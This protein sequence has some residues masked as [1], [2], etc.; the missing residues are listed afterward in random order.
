MSDRCELDDAQDAEDRDGILEMSDLTLAA[1]TDLWAL[2]GAVRPVL[3]GTASSDCWQTAR[4]TLIDVAR[5][6]PYRVVNEVEPW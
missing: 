1:I 6:W 2:I 3:A 5:R 4:G